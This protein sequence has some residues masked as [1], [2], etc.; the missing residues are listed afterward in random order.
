[1]GTQTNG[2][3]VVVQ[4]VGSRSDFNFTSD[5]AVRLGLANSPGIHFLQTGNRLELN[6][7]ASSVARTVEVFDMQGV[8]HSRILVPA[9][10]SRVT[11]PTAF[12]KGFFFQI[13]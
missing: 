7:D 9:S 10:A 5:I 1:M 3:I 13:K 11:V 8:I 4:G 2:D 6:M 12:E